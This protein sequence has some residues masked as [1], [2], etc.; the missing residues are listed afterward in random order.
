MSAVASQLAPGTWCG[1]FVERP[2]VIGA[3]VWS[4]T[5]SRSGLVAQRWL[6]PDRRSAYGF[7]LRQSEIYGLPLF[8]N[9]EPGDPA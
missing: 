2:V 4:V 3:E 9:S 6:F 5:V 7:A 8:D 1:I